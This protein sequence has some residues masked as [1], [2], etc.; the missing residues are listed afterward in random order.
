MS[1]DTQHI[2][3]ASL[4][5]GFLCA[6]VIAS[7]VALSH[8]ADKVL[9]RKSFTQTAVWLSLIPIIITVM[10]FTLSYGYLKHEELQKRV[11]NNG[12]IRFTVSDDGID[13]WFRKRP[14][15]PPVR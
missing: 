10:L 3:L 7:V 6:M 4:Y 9:Q 14:A 12:D 13:I 8:A 1:L 15:K 2:L 5:I 11:D